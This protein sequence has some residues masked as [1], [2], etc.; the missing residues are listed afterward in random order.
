MGARAFTV[1]GTSVTSQPK[2][3][4]K[5]RNRDGGL[6]LRGAAPDRSAGGN[7]PCA[8]SPAGSPCA[9][10]PC[11]GS[12]CGALGLRA[13][14]QRNGFALARLASAANE[15]EIRLSRF[16]ISRHN[17]PASGCGT[18][19]TIR[20][21]IQRHRFSMMQVSTVSGAMRG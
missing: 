17:G 20:S 21:A 10:S 18:V 16:Q 11:G 6:A 7:S 8:G 3:R 12:P 19:W 14:M 13:A 15:S 4:G 1:T 5:C 9:G 2:R